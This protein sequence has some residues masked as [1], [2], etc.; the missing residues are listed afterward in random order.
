MIKSCEY[1]PHNKKKGLGP[2]VYSFE[3]HDQLKLKLH[4]QQVQKVPSAE[5]QGPPTRIKSKRS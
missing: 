5:G 2:V 4:D 1:M 3:L